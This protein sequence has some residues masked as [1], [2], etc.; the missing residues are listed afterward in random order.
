MADFSGKSVLVV[1]DD[2]SLRRAL[3]QAL[4]GEGIEVIEAVD[5]NGAVNM[6]LSVHPDLILLDLIMPNMDGVAAL[7]RIREDVWGLT[8]KVIVLTNL[9]ED[10]TVI[11]EMVKQQP[12]Y[13]LVKAQNSLNEVIEKIKVVL[14]GPESS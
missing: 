8:A 5:G 11:N 9:D 4:Q 2:G 7:Q 1:E 13:Y 10:D 14:S 6:A 12:T 3:K